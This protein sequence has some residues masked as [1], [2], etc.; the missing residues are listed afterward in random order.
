MNMREVFLRIGSFWTRRRAWLIAS[1]FAAF[2][3]GAVVGLTGEWS[4]PGQD[5]APVN[6]GGYSIFHETMVDM[7]WPEVEKAAQE[8]AIVLM[9]TA[10]IE[11]HGPHMSCGIDTY[12]GYLMCKL[13]RR[14]LQ[15][16]GIRAVIAPPFYWGIN[17]ASHV[18][19]GTF[20]VRPETM[21]ALLHDMLSS[22]KGMGFQNVFNINAHGDGLHIRTAVE[23][24]VEARKSLGVNVRYLMSEEDAKR[25]G[26]TGSEPF[27]LIHKSPPSE[28]AQT[29]YLDLHAGAW[30]TGAVAAFFPEEVKMK[31]ARALEPTKVTM[32][33]LS[34][35]VKDMKKVTP[36]GYLGDPA[37]FDAAEAKKNVEESCRMMAEAI[38]EAMRK[39]NKRDLDR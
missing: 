16:R 2:S 31:E 9:T 19:P 20:T 13:T 1:L 6:Q 26:L 34:E 30:E 37:K 28:A 24:I 32:N 21:K 38:V 36:L 22:L 29:E 7:T 3:L 5:T 25:A 33:E 27:F 18:F 17:R 35:W 23:A 10:V 4:S 14:E 39:E 12:L 15:S 8:G 11:E